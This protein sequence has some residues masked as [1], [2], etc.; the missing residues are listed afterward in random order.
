VIYLYSNYSDRCFI[1][2]LK[3]SFSEHHTTMIIFLS[4]LIPIEVHTFLSIVVPYVDLAI[5][6]NSLMLNCCYVKFHFHVPSSI[7]EMLPYLPFQVYNVELR[8]VV[9]LQYYLVD[10]VVVAYVQFLP[11]NDHPRIKSERCVHHADEL[12]QTI[13]CNYM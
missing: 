1:G 8:M 10:K 13:H 12:P 11:M 2:F 3:F 7:L 9:V 6:I 5:S 4:S